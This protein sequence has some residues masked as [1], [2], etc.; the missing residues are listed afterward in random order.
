MESHRSLGIWLR[1]CHWR[2][3]SGSDGRK[4][5]C[6]GRRCGAGG[7]RGDE[8]ASGGGG[9]V[10]VSGVR[11]A[12]FEGFFGFCSGGS[13]RETRQHHR[14]SGRAPF[15]SKET[16]FYLSLSWRNGIGFEPN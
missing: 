11:A 10:A 3:Q 5:V 4:Y 13:A 12:E 6:N 2:F 16:G 7:D 14:L 8:G 15:G 1:C 9:V